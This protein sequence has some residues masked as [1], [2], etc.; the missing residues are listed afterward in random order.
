MTEVELIYTFAQEHVVCA[1]ALLSMLMPQTTGVGIGVTAYNVHPLCRCQ[2]VMAGFKNQPNQHRRKGVSNDHPGMPAALLILLF[3]NHGV[4]FQ[5]L[6]LQRF[7]VEST[8]VD[9]TIQ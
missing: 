4:R 8:R 1:A 3:F 9:H 5:D 2:Q 7:T 6:Q